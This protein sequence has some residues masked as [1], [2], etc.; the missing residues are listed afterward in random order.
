MRDGN[1]LLFN[2]SIFTLGTSVATLAQVAKDPKF[3][4]KIAGSGIRPT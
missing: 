2:A 1:T 3:T 4:E